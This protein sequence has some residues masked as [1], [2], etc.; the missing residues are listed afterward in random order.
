MY[1]RLSDGDQSSVNVPSILSDLSRS[2]TP[3]IPSLSGL[4]E[5][6]KP[7]RLIQILY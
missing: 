7:G 3:L 1:L 4:E 5:N 6:L 2:H